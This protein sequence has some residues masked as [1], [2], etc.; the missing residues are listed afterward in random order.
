MKK[1]AIIILVIGLFVTL[2]AGF[3]FVTRE[4]VVDLG[5]VEI[6]QKK[7]HRFGWSPALGIILVTIGA[8]VYLFTSKEK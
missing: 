8:G 3:N 5:N 1:T 2:F 7:N 6:T 4:K